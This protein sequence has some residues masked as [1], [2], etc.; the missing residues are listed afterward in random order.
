MTAMKCETLKLYD[1]HVYD[2]CENVTLDIMIRTRAPEMPIPPRP[3]DTVL[4]STKNP[5]IPTAHTVPRST[6]NPGIRI[7]RRDL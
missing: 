1:R 3:A 2:G 5:G 7:G 6:K 4:R